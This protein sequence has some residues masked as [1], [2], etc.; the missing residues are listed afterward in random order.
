MQQY[1]RVCVWCTGCECAC[2][3]P[4]GGRDAE[5]EDTTSLSLGASLAA[6]AR[7]LLVEA[8]SGRSLFKM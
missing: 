7:A 4:P 3:P 6:L 8:S 1:T 2:P 5:R